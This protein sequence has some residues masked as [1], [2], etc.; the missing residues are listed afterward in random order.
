M[1]VFHG[2]KGTQAVHDHCFHRFTSVHS[3]FTVSVFHGSI[4]IVVLLVMTPVRG[5]LERALIALMDDVL[6]R[7]CNS[8]TTHVLPLIGQGPYGSSNMKRSI[9]MLGKIDNIVLRYQYFLPCLGNR[10]SRCRYS[11][12]A[13]SGEGRGSS[14]GACLS[15]CHKQRG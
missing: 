11:P 1:Y 14:I 3:C 2:K 9:Q 12:L 8:N 5:Y 7:Q 4:T 10:G 6:C 15:P 13:R